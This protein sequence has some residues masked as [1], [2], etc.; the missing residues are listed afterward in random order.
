MNTI[1]EHKSDELNNI[2]LEI[3]DLLTFSRHL[4][5]QEITIYNCIHKGVFCFLDAECFGCDLGEECLNILYKFDEIN[6]VSNIN[7]LINKLIISKKYIQR[8]IDVEHHDTKLCFCDTCNWNKNT[9]SVLSIF[10]DK[11]RNI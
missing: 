5:Q 11:Y 7:I 1:N 9:Q 8:K 6:D 10:E 2:N 3:K 4:L